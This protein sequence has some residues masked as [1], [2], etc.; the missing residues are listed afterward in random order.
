MATITITISDVKDSNVVK[1]LE[2]LQPLKNNITIE[3][4]EQSEDLQNFWEKYE[5]YIPE[6]NHSIDPD[7]LAINISHFKTV[8]KKYEMYSPASKIMTRVFRNNIG[9][10]CLG[11]KPIRSKIQ[12][13]VVHCWV[14]ERSTK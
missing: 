13:K 7:L 3:E 2:K 9:K 10:G 11:A 1:W 5:K 14:F 4:L 8:M 6:I 12:N